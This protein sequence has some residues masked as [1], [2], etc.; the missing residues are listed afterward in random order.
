MVIGIGTRYSDFTTASRTAFQ[1]PDVRFVNINVAGMDVIK[2]AGLGV[3]RRQGS[4][5]GPAAPAGWLLGGRELRPVDRRAQC[6][7]GRNR[8]PRLPA[9]NPGPITDEVRIG[10][11]DT[12]AH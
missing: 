9:R 11:I 8:T 5:R 4:A 2:H 1:N 12:P 3:Q 10:P 6:Q 7:V